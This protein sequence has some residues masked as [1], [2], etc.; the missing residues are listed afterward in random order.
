MSK[1]MEGVREY[2]QELKRQIA[3]RSG[4]ASDNP[5]VAR[6][7]G[8]E[9]PDDVEIVE[10]TY[11]DVTQHLAVTLRVEKQFSLPVSF[12]FIS[13]VVTIGVLSF[14]LSTDPFWTNPKVIRAIYL[15]LR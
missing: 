8:D 10:Q 9:L 1:L 13:E 12:R 14:P 5:H 2:E 3:A 15:S 6:I 4:R 11:D 7:L